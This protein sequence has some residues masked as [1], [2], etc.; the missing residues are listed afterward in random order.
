M[1]EYLR[2]MGLALRDQRF[3]L[4]TIHFQHLLGDWPTIDWRS[5]YGSAHWMPLRDFRALGCAPKSNDTRHFRATIDFW[6]AEGVLFDDIRLLPDRRHVQWRCSKFAFSMMSEMD[7]YALLTTESLKVARTDLDMD[8]L[9]QIALHHK[10]QRPE[11]RM[12]GTRFLDPA[13]ASAPFRLKDVD[14]KLKDTLSRFAK[15]TGYGFVV[16]YCQ[17]GNAPGYTEVIIRIQHA[18]TVWPFERIQK[19]PPRTRQFNFLP[20]SGWP[21]QRKPGQH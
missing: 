13:S 7:R 17:G 12:F 5:E 21:K 18:G 1:I 4:A 8:V 2:A 6:T 15:L 20:A 10:M 19:F 3:L 16:G 14:R 9:L 11:F